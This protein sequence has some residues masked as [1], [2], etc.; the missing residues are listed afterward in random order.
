MTEKLLQELVAAVENHYGVEN[1]KPLLLARFGQ[2]APALSAELKMEYGSLGAAVRKVGSEKLKI[3][4]AGSGRQVVAPASNADGIGQSLEQQSAEQKAGSSSFDGL[5]T[6]VQ[7]AFCVK[8]SEGQG[9]AVRVAP[10]FKYIKWK[11][12][13]ALK[14]GF[15]AID[16]QFRR[17]GFVVRDATVAEKDELWRKFIAWCETQKVDPTSF[18]AGHPSTALGRLIAAQTADVVTNLVIPADIAAILLR[19]P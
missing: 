5:P 10:P 18:Q 4:N 13:G 14:P 19:H 17:P 15:K 1:P 7:I 2:I 3:L 8:V 12:G 6:P 11:V 9:V 16:E